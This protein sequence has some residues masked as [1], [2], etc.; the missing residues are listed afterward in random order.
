MSDILIHIDNTL[1]Q[2]AK[3]DLEGQLLKQSGV[4]RAVTS[5]SAQ[6]LMIVDFD[7]DQTNSMNILH[8][9]HNSGYHAELIGL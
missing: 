4:R 1:D 3:T 9:V 2:A 8:T 7:H 5:A 6:H